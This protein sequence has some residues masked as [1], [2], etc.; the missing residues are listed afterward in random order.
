MPSGIRPART[1]LLLIAR[2]TLLPAIGFLGV[3]AGCDRPAGSGT[4]ST[5]LLASP[6]LQHVVALQTARDARALVRLLEDDDSGV[7]ARAAFALGSVQDQSTA[8]ALIERLADEEAA[9]R[10]EAAFALGQLP[11][12]AR[13]IESALLE[14]AEGESDRRARTRVIAALGTA[15]REPASEWLAQLPSTD[16]DYVAATLALARTLARGVAAGPAVEALV[17]RLSDPE[18]EVRELAASGLANALV[19]STWSSRRDLVYQA[20]D[21]Y[22][23]SDP[24]AVQLLRAL[25]RVR[26]PAAKE[27]VR[28]WLEESPDWR[29][30]AA[31]V[32]GLTAAAAPEDRAALLT[33]LDD[34]SPHVRRA[35]GAALLG[36]PLE[37][38]EL[39]RIVRWVDAHPDDLLTAGALM[40]TLAARG[41]GAAAISWLERLPHD[42]PTG[43]PAAIDAVTLLP[44]APAT[45]A[46][47]EAA[48]SP[49]PAISGA[50]AR[51]LA[52]RWASEREGPELHPLYYQA[53]ARALRERDPAL[54]P[55]LERLL[56]DPAF[57][58]LGSDS[59]L[60]DARA[61][62][63]APAPPL[64]QPDWVALRELGRRPRLALETERGS[65][66]VE[67]FPDQAPLTVQTV[68]RLAREGRY[69]GVPFHRVLPNFM[70]QGG[71]VVR[72][73][74]L[75]DP[76]F[77]IPSELTHVRYERGTAGMART[78]KDSE[79]SQFFLTH[80]IQPHL[81][82]AYTA[83][84]RVV[85]GVEVLDALREGD[86]IVRARIEPGPAERPEEG[87][88]E[89][90]L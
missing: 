19:E 75:G 30:R 23:K 79:T 85:E 76:G 81:D 7:R 48:R 82:G 29:V 41:R 35:A 80:S 73:D 90:A 54:V 22:D 44:G 2:A 13:E 84:G 61:A 69:D 9:V 77:R 53:F 50:A 57:R 32:E 3:L 62:A 12:F 51:A 33:A 47:A 8:E 55:A 68:A 5:D 16:P 25:L 34:P 86:R 60:T 36:T 78:E 56:S 1:R 20:F 89:P 70:A 40:R 38:A 88:T 15:G 71:D 45:R 6:A 58:T 52:V 21:G 63:A 17:A 83:F 14:A 65:L 27:R 49:V 18:P 10:A 59:L 72:G 43:W 74:G 46:L 24:A 66:T 37:P 64:V 39:D 31:A 28:A 4:P 11:Q 67:L 26:D 42:D 87:A